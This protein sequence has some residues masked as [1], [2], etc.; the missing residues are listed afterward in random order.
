M[1]RYQTIPIVSLYGKRVYAN[2][3][4]PEIAPASSDT[5]VITSDGDR[6]DTLAN[7]YYG[8]PSLWWIISIANQE[9]PQDS[10]I[11]PPGTQLRI[12][13]NPAAINEE[14]RLLNQ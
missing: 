4:Y 14:F 5:Y 6:F 10:L 13:A 12:P 7:Q 2:L 8:D 9:L 1:S 3:R 11:P